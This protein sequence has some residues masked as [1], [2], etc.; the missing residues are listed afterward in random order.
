MLTPSHFFPTEGWE[1]IL[2]SG[3]GLL[4]IPRARRGCSLETF[5]NML[6]NLWPHERE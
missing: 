5:N 3:P 4:Y 6:G 2:I 1:Y